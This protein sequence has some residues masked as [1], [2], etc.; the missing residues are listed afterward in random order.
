MTILDVLELVLKGIIFTIKWPVTV[1]ISHNQSQSQSWLFGVSRHL[2]SRSY[3]WFVL[4]LFLSWTITIPHWLIIPIQSPLTQLIWHI[5][6]ALS[7]LDCGLTHNLWHSYCGA[8][9]A[10][11]PFRLFFSQLLSFTDRDTLCLTYNSY[12]FY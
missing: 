10:H 3:G 12:S 8:Q 4:Q 5:Y 7:Q 2:T 1:L 9:S 6:C 11:S